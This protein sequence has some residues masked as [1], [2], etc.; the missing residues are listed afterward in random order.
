MTVK[1]RK[2]ILPLSIA[3]AAI[4]LLTI[5]S[6]DVYIYFKEESEVDGIKLPRDFYIMLDYPEKARIRKSN[7]KIT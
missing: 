3:S 1:L 7:C 2:F 5:F 4:A 6:V